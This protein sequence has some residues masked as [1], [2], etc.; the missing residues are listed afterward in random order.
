MAI[1]RS[2]WNGSVVISTVPCA[3]GFS[4]GGGVGQVLIAVVTAGLDD[5]R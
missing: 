1:D 5:G 3:P 2:S 4:I